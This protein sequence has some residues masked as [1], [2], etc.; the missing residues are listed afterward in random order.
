M[1]QEPFEMFLQFFKALGDETR[2]RIVALLGERP[3]SVGDLA[4]ALGL[5]EPTVSHHLARLREAGLVNLRAVGTSRIYR[6][7]ERNLARKAAAVARLPGAL[8]AEPVNKPD[9]GWIDALNVSEADRKV[10]KDYLW[11]TALK[12]IPTKQSK[13][14]VVLRW[15]AGKFEPG[16]HYTEREV[17]EILKPVH[18]DYA[19]LR[20]ELIDFKFLERAPGGSLY[21]LAPRQPEI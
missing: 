7:D 15:L 11:G 19:R 2:L 18:A 4:A 5:S 16:R 13:L 9:M 17:N 21:W 8:R 10:L 3:R 1:N 20:R 6:L 12:H 14:L